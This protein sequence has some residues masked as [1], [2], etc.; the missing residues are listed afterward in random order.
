[1][2]RDKL[3]LGVWLQ[4]YEA[5]HHGS[6]EVVVDKV[7]AEMT[8]TELRDLI[9]DL[10]EEKLL[11]LVMDPDKGLE[12]N[13]SLQDRLV[14]QTH[15]VAEGERGEPLESVIQRLAPI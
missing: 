5:A 11:G 13:R 2:L 3:I 10:L 8:E 9:G 1:M 12:L 6:Q 15:E 14:R 4:T 7:V